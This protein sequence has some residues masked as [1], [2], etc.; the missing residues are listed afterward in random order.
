[1]REE[2]IAVYHGRTADDTQRLADKLREAGI[3][4]YA[5]TTQAPMYGMRAGPGGNIL[6]VEGPITEHVREIVHRFRSDY[7]GV[8]E[9][10]ERNAHE[11]GLELPTGDRPRDDSF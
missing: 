3:E 2:L 7:P 10:V 11:T 6:F 1:M 4:S 8:V 9:R 5:S